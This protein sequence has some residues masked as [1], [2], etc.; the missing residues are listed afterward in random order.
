MYLSVTRPKT[1]LKLSKKRVRSDFFLLS[2]FGFS[3]IAHKAGL[4][5][6]AL[7]AEKMTEIAIVIENC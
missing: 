1:R 6:S 4:S 7:K 5:V 2:D 3:S